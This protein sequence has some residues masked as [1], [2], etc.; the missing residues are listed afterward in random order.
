MAVEIVV[1][2]GEFLGAL[3]F[4]DDGSGRSTDAEIVDSHMLAGSLL[5]LDDDQAET[6]AFCRQLRLRSEVDDWLNENDIRPS[7][8]AELVDAGLLRSGIDSE[9]GRW[10]A[11]CVIVPWGRS[12]GWN[13]SLTLLAPSNEAFQVSPVYYWLWLYS[14]TGR[15]IEEVLHFLRGS[16][17]VPEVESA[18]AK[19]VSAAIVH[20]LSVGLGRLE[21]PAL[22]TS[23][24]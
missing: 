16:A 22:P 2:V 17:V 6:M 24:D 11:D 4:H 10:L 12:L 18:G 21:L 20:L 3:P 23:D 9:A 1:P 13:K 14:R 8:I 19:D 7:I 5:R 15:S